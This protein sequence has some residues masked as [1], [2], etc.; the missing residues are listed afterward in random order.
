MAHA[1][2][3]DPTEG[4]VVLADV[5]ES[6]IDRYATRHDPRD[7]EVAQL[8]IV[9]EWIDCQRAVVTVDIVGDLLPIFSTARADGGSQ[10]PMAG[11]AVPNNDR[12]QDADLLPVALAPAAPA[13]VFNE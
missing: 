9:S 12:E 6:F 11:A 10:S 5:Q 1:A 13:V 2:R 3:P 7:V 4:Q 8:G